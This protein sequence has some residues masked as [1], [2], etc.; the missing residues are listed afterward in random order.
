MFSL[1]KPGEFK[2]TKIGLENFERYQKYLANELDG[3]EG[4]ST[5]L[6]LGPQKTGTLWAEKDP[7]KFSIPSAKDYPFKPSVG[8]L[9]FDSIEGEKSVKDFRQKV[10]YLHENRHYIL[11]EKSMGDARLL[12]L[13]VENREKNGDTAI[14]SNMKDWIDHY[15]GKNEKKLITNVTPEEDLMTKTEQNTI[16]K[17]PSL[18]EKDVEYPKYKELLNKNTSI[19]DI[20]KIGLELSTLAQLRTYIKQFEKM[21]NRVNERVGINR[22]FLETQMQKEFADIWSKY[23]ANIR[24]V[25]FRS[26]ELSILE[27]PTKDWKTIKQ[28]VNSNGYVNTLQEYMDLKKKFMQR[29]KTAF[30]KFGAEE[31][32]TD[33]LFE[34]TLRS[35]LL[36]DEKNVFSRMTGE[37]LK[38]IRNLQIVSQWNT[39]MWNTLQKVF[40]VEALKGKSNLEKNENIQDSEDIEVFNHLNRDKLLSTPQKKK[41]VSFSDEDQ[42]I[43]DG[44]SKLMAEPKKAS[45]EMA[46]KELQDKMLREAKAKKEVLESPGITKPVLE[47][48]VENLKGVWPGNWAIFQKELI[49]TVREEESKIPEQI[50]EILPPQFDVPEAPKLPTEEDLH[51]VQAEYVTKLAARKALKAEKIELQ[52]TLEKMTPNTFNSEKGDE[53]RDKIENIDKM[54]QYM[55]EYF[56]ESETPIRDAFLKSF[57]LATSLFNSTKDLLL[58]GTSNV[59]AKMGETFK[60]GAL[61]GDYWKRG[62]KQKVFITLAMTTLFLLIAG[63]TIGVPYVLSKIYYRNA[64]NNV[65]KRPLDVSKAP[66]TKKK[67]VE[68]S[69]TKE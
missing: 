65:V 48:A 14:R 16:F 26:L 38:Q 4:E 59:S 62:L 58:S 46:F 1:F 35:Y 9:K 49:D 39:K 60:R 52:N 21:D 55:D 10:H 7:E 42:M 64:D 12:K 28:E 50:I 40:D 25:L 69:P 20:Q 67:K 6:G 27:I 13:Y 29:T 66:P 19:K 30:F 43:E 23:A 68:E 45:E 3:Y 56:M 22:V 53:V 8:D 24:S 34:D 57:S 33:S 37:N 18:L 47:Q 51:R 17:S 5:F 2:E 61:I 31:D 36:G 41:F 11:R 63:G 54:E 32:V 15:K 44:Y